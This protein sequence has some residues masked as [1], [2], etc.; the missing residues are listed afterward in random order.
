MPVL[1]LSLHAA[2]IGILCLI[3][4]Q[5]WLAIVL[6]GCACDTDHLLDYFRWSRKF[7]LRFFLTGEYAKHIRPWFVFHSVEIAYILLVS[8]FFIS[9]LWLDFFVFAYIAHL[10]IDSFT[11]DNPMRLFAIWRITDDSV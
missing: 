7:N 11:W 10:I 4:P 5:Y 1:D 2:V 9:S 6:G 8:A 3:A